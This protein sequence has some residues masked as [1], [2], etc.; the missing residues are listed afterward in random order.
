MK[1]NIEKI[2]VGLA[3]MIIFTSGT[4]IGATINDF[5]IF[6]KGEKVT[7]ETWLNGYN[8]DVNEIRRATA[9]YTYTFKDGSKSEA[10]IYYNGEIYLPIRK[11][12]EFTNTYYEKNDTD[13][14]FDTTRPYQ[15]EVVTSSN[16]SEPQADPYLNNNTSEGNW[17]IT[18]DS[19]KLVVMDS[20]GYPFIIQNKVGS[21]ECGLEEKGED[22]ISGYS[23]IATD[24]NINITHI[25]YDTATNKF[26]LDADTN[27]YT[28]SYISNSNINAA[29]VG[30]VLISA[31]YTNRDTN[32]TINLTNSQV[33][34]DIEYL[35]NYYRNIIEENKEQLLENGNIP[36][37]VTHNSISNNS[38]GT[39]EAN[40]SFHNISDKAIKAFKVEFHCYNDFDS[41]VN[42]VASYSNK[43][44]GIVQNK[45]IIPDDTST[46]T[47]TL[48]LYDN[49]TNIKYIKITEIV[50]SDGTIWSN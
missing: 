44:N 34:I 18:E 8:V 14:I 37:V 50:Y 2:I 6:T 32:N 40:I 27:V 12:A 13:I 9:G 22:S 41:P 1:K 7:I 47:W 24:K 5:S 31:S 19:R 29:Y 23:Y 49:T 26:Y 48:S 28:Y 10:S 36:L 11:M 3:V 35:K 25:L 20:D 17:V 46:F 16:D 45:H 38:I 39:P 4:I 21:I 30:S 43:F 42:K 15:G 33:D